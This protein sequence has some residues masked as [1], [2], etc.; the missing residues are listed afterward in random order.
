MFSKTVDQLQVDA[1]LAL[2]EISQSVSGGKNLWDIPEVVADFFEAKL[3]L[4][5][6]AGDERMSQGAR[7]VLAYRAVIESE[8]HFRT[9]I[10]ESEDLPNSIWEEWIELQAIEKRA[11]SQRRSTRQIRIAKSLHNLKLAVFVMFLAFAG[12]V[13]I[14]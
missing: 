13:F 12:L 9:L 10:E 7:S 1:E 5:S 2:R 4:Q 6:R 11:R 3:E 14:L 8:N